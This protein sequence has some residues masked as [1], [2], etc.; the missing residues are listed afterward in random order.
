MTT[1]AEYTD[2]ERR[3][4]SY[5]T[6]HQ[7]VEA[8]IP[9]FM[10]IVAFVCPFALIFPNAWLW[11]QSTGIAV[12]IFALGL[13]TTCASCAIIA[14]YGDS[15][16]NP[17]NTTRNLTMYIGFMVF[18][19]SLFFDHLQVIKMSSYI[20]PVFLMVIFFL[21]F[22]SLEPKHTPMFYAGAMTAVLGYAML[23]LTAALIGA[24]DIDY[25]RGPLYGL[26]VVMYVWNSI[27]SVIEGDQILT[28]DPHYA[29]MY[30][31]IRPFQFA[32]SV[33]E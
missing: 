2:A 12:P 15:L 29:A 3:T 14:T 23:L 9:A 11:I 25:I 19:F 13:I 10:I 20:I 27:K 21:T 33:L 30:P 17:K 4:I 22:K 24:K 1:L 5:R 8:L 32:L 18:G 31:I 28:I 26:I 6:Y 7:I 16:P